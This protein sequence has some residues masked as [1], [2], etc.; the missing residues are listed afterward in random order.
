MTLLISN[1]KRGVVPGKEQHMNT[2][3]VFELK[4][5]SSKTFLIIRS[6]QIFCSGGWKYWYLTGAIAMFLMILI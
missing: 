6:I 3:L 4:L 5:I 2:H 1:G